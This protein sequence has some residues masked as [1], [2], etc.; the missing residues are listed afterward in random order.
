MTDTQTLIEALRILTR[1]IESGDGVAN[2]CIAEAADRL[3][4]LPRLL[5]SLQDVIRIC[6]AMRYTVGLGKNQLER[7]ERAEAVIKKAERGAA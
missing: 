2:A 7:I 5:E 1:D 4:E 3:E 6:K